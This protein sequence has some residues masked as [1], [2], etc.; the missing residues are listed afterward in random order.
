MAG[1]NWDNVG[2][3][4]VPSVNLVNGHDK[5]IDNMSNQTTSL[6]RMP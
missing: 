6:V 4:Y 2:S 3:A 5:L 1:I